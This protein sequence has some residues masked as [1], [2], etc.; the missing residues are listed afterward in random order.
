M[1][2]E[3]QDNFQA[4]LKLYEAAK[5]DGDPD[6]VKYVRDELAT[7]GC[8]EDDLKRDFDTNRHVQGNQGKI[9]VVQR[10]G[11]NRFFDVTLKK[12]PRTM[13]LRA[14]LLPTGPMDN[15]REHVSTK[16]A[17]FIAKHNLLRG[18]S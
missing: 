12:S 6:L 13:A 2:I 17:P 5:P 15:W 7:A 16:V 8:P 3:T 1:N 9:S 18:Q 11:M 10:V 14:D 4:G